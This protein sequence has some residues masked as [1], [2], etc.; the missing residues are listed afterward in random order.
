MFMNKYNSPTF[1]FFK[2][3]FK[4]IEYFGNLNNRWPKQLSLRKLE[5]R[6]G[7]KKG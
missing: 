7:Y 2:R 4:K 6:N 1:K 5:N 3:I